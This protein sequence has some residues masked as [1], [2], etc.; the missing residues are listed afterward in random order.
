MKKK[1]VT[2]VKHKKTNKSQ[3]VLDN[4]LLVMFLVAAITS[5]IIMPSSA[6]AA[7]MCDTRCYET[8]NGG[9]TCNT[10]CYGE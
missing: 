1:K 4:V 9:Q 8:Y 7:Q 3:D 6:F 2:N 5:I 10:I